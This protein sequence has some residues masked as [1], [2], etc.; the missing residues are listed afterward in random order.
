MLA[1]E[2]LQ[3]ITDQHLRKMCGGREDHPE[4]HNKKHY[5]CDDDQVVDKL[6]AAKDAVSVFHV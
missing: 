3:A 5:A 4:W 2:E 1:R 6:P